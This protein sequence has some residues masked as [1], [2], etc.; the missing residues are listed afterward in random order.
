MA[1][2]GK[3][4]TEVS[5]SF[6]LIR[7]YNRERGLAAREDA[8]ELSTTT[9]KGDINDASYGHCEGEQGFRGGRSTGRKAPY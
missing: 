6:D 1:A 2:A 8:T 9:N 7:L 5:I 4:D 3:K